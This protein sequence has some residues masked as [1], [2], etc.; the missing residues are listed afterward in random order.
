MIHTTACDVLGILHPIVQAGMAGPKH[1]NAELVAAV[2]NAG[3]LGILGCLER[4]ADQA[5][6]EIR[7]IR[8]LTDRPFGVNF[9]L[10]QRDDA[11]FDA[12]LAERVPV[13]SFFRGDPAES[14][15]RAREAG[16]RTIYQVTTVAEA[17]DACAMGVDVLV[18]QGHEAGGHMGPLPLFGF[19]PEVVAVAGARPVLAAGG[20]VDGRGLAAALC[21]GAA[22]VLMG[23]RFLATPESPASA[24]HK[25]ALLS[26]SGPVATVASGIFDVLWESDWPGVQARALRNRLTARWVG[27]EGE[28]RAHL[29]EA[30]AALQ[31]AQE[32]G[33]PEEMILLAGMGAG[34][35]QDLKPAGQVV[36]D[37]IAEAAQILH[38]WGMR[39]E[40]DAP[41]HDLPYLPALP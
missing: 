14:V 17:I 8:A 13:F 18:A 7:R 34:C 19:L 3:G 40:R 36:H 31:Q 15:A 25:Q 20:I 24:I 26:A 22:G 32:A 27:R 30:Q 39:V 16:A 38:D 10:H 5:V 35:I 33:N 2:S 12:C 9:V 4:P 11:A 21:L 41:H 23:T 37:I 6:A 29:A 1:T 28:L